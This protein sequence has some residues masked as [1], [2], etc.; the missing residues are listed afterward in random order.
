MYCSLDFGC[1]KASD[2][3]HIVSH[4]VVGG[5]V[6]RYS[7]KPEEE[8]QDIKVVISDS[9]KDSMIIFE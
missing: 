4:Q 9:M 1:R 2:G 3:I 5:D 6:F 8:R 7:L